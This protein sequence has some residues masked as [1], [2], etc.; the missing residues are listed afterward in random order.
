MIDAFV[1]ALRSEVGGVKI[2]FLA[3]DPERFRG[4]F[5]HLLREGHCVAPSGSLV[6]TQK[7]G[8]ARVGHLAKCAIHRRTPRPSFSHAVAYCCCCETKHRKLPEAFRKF[9]ETVQGADAVVIGGGGALTDVFHMVRPTY[10]TALTAHCAKVPVFAVGQSIGPFHSKASQ[11]L[12]RHLV[13]MCQFFQ[14]REG[15]GSMPW[16]EKIGADPSKVEVGADSAML[17]PTGDP[18]EAEAALQAAFGATP[19]RLMTLNPRFLPESNKGVPLEKHIALF[20]ELVQG[21]IDRYDLHVLSIPSLYKAVTQQAEK[22]HMDRPVSHRIRERLKDPSRFAVLE[23]SPSIPEVK[24]LHAR[25]KLSVGVGYHPCLFALSVG[26]P[27]AVLGPDPYYGV[28]NRGLA[29]LFEVPD[30][31]F[32]GQKPGWTKTV[33]ARAEA[34]LAQEPELRPRLVA[35]AEALRDVAAGTVQRVADSL[36]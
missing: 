4:A 9:K 25:A 1:E 3:H 14:L 6:M 27:C 5:P 36:R 10:L 24:A 33:L 26:T 13:K 8:L 12:M 23:A 21:L 29:D 28:K 20:A 17:I 34:M 11:C 7:E 15:T 22:P 18:H 16:I 31:Y 30:L 2:V 19:S 32:E 35:R